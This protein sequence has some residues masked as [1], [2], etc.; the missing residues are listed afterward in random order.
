MLDQ[1]NVFK[2]ISSHFEKNRPV[3][4][5]FVLN[6][7]ALFETMTGV[8]KTDH[9]QV[10]LLRHGCLDEFIKS[11]R[12]FA[13]LEIVVDRYEFVEDYLNG[14]ELFIDAP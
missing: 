14:R 7:A 5:D 1:K 11:F 13:I 3:N 4:L 6:S 8:L 12:E 10:M 2:M 9:T